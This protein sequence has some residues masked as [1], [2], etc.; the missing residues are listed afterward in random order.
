MLPSCGLELILT[1]PQ[2]CSLMI[3][4]DFPLFLTFSAFLHMYV[5]FLSVL[6]PV[7][8]L[9]GGSDAVR[10]PPGPW[11]VSDLDIIVDPFPPSPSESGPGTGVSGTSSSSIEGSDQVSCEWDDGV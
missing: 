11:K 1:S 3:L 9:S 8:F 7:S 4:T 5:C 6:Q 2:Y 10:K